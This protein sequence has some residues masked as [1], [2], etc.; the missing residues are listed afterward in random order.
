MI[1]DEPHDFFQAHYNLGIIFNNLGE[2]QKAIN[3]FEKVIK[4][5]PDDIKSYNILGKDY[6]HCICSHP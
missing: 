1:Y 4:Y 6:C 5:Q 2:Y 3:C